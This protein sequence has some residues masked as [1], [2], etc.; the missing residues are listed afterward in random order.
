MAGGG[1]R[2]IRKMRLREGVE[3]F[4]EAGVDHETEAYPQLGKPLDLSPKHRCH[5]NPVID[6]QN[7]NSFIFGRSYLAK[8]IY[9]SSH[10]TSMDS[11][12][13]IGKAR[14]LVAPPLDRSPVCSC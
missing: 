4:L 1:T 3:V 13:L 10:Y 7:M 14:I 12:W 5:Q 9:Y 2:L 6:I 8:K 11:I